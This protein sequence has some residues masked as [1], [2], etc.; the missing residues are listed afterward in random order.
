LKLVVL[1]FLGG[2]PPRDEE[3]TIPTKGLKLVP[4]TEPPPQSLVDEERAILERG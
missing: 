1:L 4:F 3:R 2:C